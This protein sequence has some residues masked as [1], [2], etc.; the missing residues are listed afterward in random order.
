MHARVECE[1]DL[2]QLERSRLEAE[3]TKWNPDIPA[4][5]EIWGGHNH[6]HVKVP[7]LTC[8]VRKFPLVADSLIIA[9]ES[10]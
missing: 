1:T 4:D 10:L 9:E 8:W 3:V 5:L 6:H 2:D 7:V